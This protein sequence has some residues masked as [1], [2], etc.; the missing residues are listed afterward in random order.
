MLS[1]S[2]HPVIAALILGGVL[3]IF[4]WGKS[5]VFRV[6]RAGA[7]IIGAVALIGFGTISFEDAVKSVDYKTIV[8]LFSMMLS[9]PI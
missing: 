4:T 8:I 3:I 6:D 7:S 1:D 9:W 5:P 2:W